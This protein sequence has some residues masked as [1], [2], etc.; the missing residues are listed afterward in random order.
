MKLL[1]FSSFAHLVLDRDP[2]RVSGGA[3]LQMGL[4]ARELARRG[5][6]VTLLGADEGQPDARVLDDVR[7]RT[8]GRFDTGALGDTLRAF[9]RVARVLREER[10]EWVIIM[11]AGTWVWFLWLLKLRF[12]YALAFIAASDVDVDGGYRRMF[13]VRGWLYEMALRRTNR[14]IAMSEYQRAGLEKSGLRPGFFRNLLLDAPGGGGAKD[15]DFLWVSSAQPLKQPGIFLDLAARLPDRKFVMICPLKQDRAFWEATRAQAATLAN[16]EFHALVPYH[17]I[18]SFFHRARVFVNT[19]DYE[20]FPNTFLHA[21]L[22]HAALLSLRVDPDGMLSREGAGVCA[23]G[24]PAAFH[25]AAAGMIGDAETLARMQSQCTTYVA[26]RHGM[27][28]NVDAFLAVL[29]RP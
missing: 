25:A 12:G 15:I 13:P 10:P 28:E 17:S 2:R 29:A 5:H 11:G 21:G 19:S 6:A 9:V 3:E 14:V 20:G 16:V 18:Q 27:A 1:L 23:G 26:A 7:T 22:G 4:L 8:G 24:A